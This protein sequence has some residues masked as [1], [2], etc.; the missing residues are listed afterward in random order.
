[1]NYHR[2]ANS[3]ERFKQRYLEQSKNLTST[4]RSE[5]RNN[6]PG[7]NGSANRSGNCL[8]TQRV[9]G[10]NTR[11]MFE[12]GKR[13]VNRDL[14]D[15]RFRLRAG[16]VEDQSKWALDNLKTSSPCCVIIHNQE[17][18]NLKESETERFADI[19]WRSRISGRSQEPLESQLRM[20]S[21]HA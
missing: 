11:L 12:K 1:M 15:Q 14:K 21:E 7:R 13:I 16:K 8:H 3:R 19:Y 18:V 20:R 6:I 10:V 2:C 9:W 4:D 17:L 5:F